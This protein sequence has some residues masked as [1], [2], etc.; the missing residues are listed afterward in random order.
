MSQRKSQIAKDIL[1]RVRWL[2]IIFLLLGIFIVARIIW[3]QYG[4]EADGLKAKAH[5]ITFERMALPAERGDILARDGRILATSVPTYEIRMDFAADGLDHDTFYN[6]VDSLSY[7]LSDFFR[8]KSAT[9]YKAMLVKEYSKKQKDRYKLILPRRISHLEEKVVS[10][11]P[12]FRL[13]PNRGGFIK[14]QINKRVLP[15]GSLAKRTIGSFISDS[16][17]YGIEG[18]FNNQLKG[19]DGATLMQRISGS[20]K[21]PVPDPMNIE[22]VHGMDVVTTIDVDLQD[23][24]ER[25]LKERLDESGANWGTV[26]LM[27]V[28][29]GEIHA[30]ANITRTKTGQF[31]EDY[32]YAIGRRMEPGSTF[33]LATL[34][35]L[36]EDGKMPLDHKIDCENGTARVGMTERTKKLVID[37]HRE[38]VI[39]LRRVFEVSSNIG[40]AKAVN[41]TYGTD[42]KRF[43]NFINDMGFNEPLGVQIAGERNP[44]VKTPG[45]RNWDGTSLV[46]MSYGYALEITPMHTLALYNAVANN[47]RL[48]RPQLV[49]EVRSYGKPV[50]KF[51]SEDIKSAICSKQTVAL[52]RECLEGV[53]DEGTG[54]ILKNPYYTVAA[55][56]G[57]AQMPFDNG[58]Y[59][60]RYG[61]RNYLATMVGYFPADNPKYSCIV[62]IQTY[63][64]P[65]SRYTYYG[66]SLAGPVFKAISDRV[67]AA[68]PTWH[69]PVDTSGDLKM[70]IAEDIKSG[71]S[72]QIRDAAKKINVNV[73]IKRKA[74]EWGYIGQ[75]L[76]ALHNEFSGGNNSLARNNNPTDGELDVKSKNILE[77]ETMDLD[78][79]VVPSVVGMG[80]KDAIFLLEKQGL[81]VAFKGKGTIISQSIEAGTEARKGAVI[82]LT[83]DS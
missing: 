3:I 36:L 52:V 34:I 76:R 29:T 49:K 82:V 5:Q 10:Q 27:E 50:Y 71:K 65:G 7:Y 74:E 80:L 43:V 61:G 64:G 24:A 46:M 57:T 38:S 40:M 78:N 83:M 54:K 31:L 81:K 32:N 66:A 2:Y 11:F 53:V 22:P 14:R 35:A 19:T 73:D 56:T 33:K 8:D 69:T 42:P 25:A 58:G 79:G 62:A 4:K 17:K 51:K 26:V 13:G 70:P 20:F 30:M 9:A 68:N 23:V 75:G 60:D 59:K 63:Y 28:A 6:N 67:Y 15:H 16:I 41:D 12:I 44:L 48:L 45:T 39:S 21:V 72:M 47:G 55:K 1:N 77:V 18:S 37:S